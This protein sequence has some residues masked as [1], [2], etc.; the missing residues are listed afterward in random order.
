MRFFSHTTLGWDEISQDREPEMLDLKKITPS[1]VND[2]PWI[3][4][5][6]M[7]TCMDRDKTGWLIIDATT[8]FAM[9]FAYSKPEAVIALCY[10]VY[11]LKIDKEKLLAQSTDLIA[12]NGPSPMF[13]GV[14]PEDLASNIRKITSQ[15]E[16]IDA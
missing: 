16:K 6:P 1:F 13:G 5:I 4:D 2:Y 8:G 11:F 10:L 12:K 15:I 14:L 3:M 7:F 9:A